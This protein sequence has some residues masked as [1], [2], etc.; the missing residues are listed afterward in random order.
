MTESVTEIVGA[1]VM[2]NGDVPDNFM[3]LARTYIFLL[4]TYIHVLGTYWLV[5]LNS[6]ANVILGPSYLPSLALHVQS[7]LPLSDLA[8]YNRCGTWLAGGMRQISSQLTTYTYLY[9]H[10]ARLAG[11][12]GSVRNEV[13]VSCF[14]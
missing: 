10:V 14:H 13:T 8:S 9:R 7:P 3:Y 2:K 1:S 12:Q 6:L 5:A 4:G 11:T